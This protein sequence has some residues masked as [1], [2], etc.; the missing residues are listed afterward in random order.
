MPNSLSPFWGKRAFQ[1]VLASCGQFVALTILAMLVYPGGTNAD[2]TTAGYSFFTNFFSDLGRTVAHNGQ[3]NSIASLLFPIALTLAG[4][5][6]ILFF[7]TF[8]QF[9][10]Q[11]AITKIL[12]AAGALAGIGAGLCF[13]GV[14]FTPSNLFSS[15]HGTFVLSAFGLFFVAV[16]IYVMAMLIEKNYPSRNALIFI[17][18]A[19]ALGVYVWLMVNGPRGNSP[20]VAW[21]QPTAQKVIVYA[22]LLSVALQSW[23]A[24]RLT[25]SRA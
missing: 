12:S 2:K 25:Q 19:V 5:G 1:I 17:A 11:S 14:A 21:I 3:P 20:D 9:F 16:S 13:I 8:T 4:S 22:S 24:I 15:A 23:A 18:F 6:L 7:I 10:R